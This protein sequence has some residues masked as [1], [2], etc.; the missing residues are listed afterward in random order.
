MWRND[1]NLPHKSTS[2]AE[3]KNI[4]TSFNNY[5]SFE[6]WLLM[7]FLRYVFRIIFNPPKNLR[8]AALSNITRTKELFS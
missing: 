6:Q 4:I 1:E 8:T 2:T 3:I 5:E 7:H